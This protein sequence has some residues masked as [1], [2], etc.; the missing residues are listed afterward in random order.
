M[1]LLCCVEI[2]RRAVPADRDG[3]LARLI[4]VVSGRHGDIGLVEY[5]ASVFL[6]TR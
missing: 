2:S 3:G 4:D 1:L 6:C 5:N